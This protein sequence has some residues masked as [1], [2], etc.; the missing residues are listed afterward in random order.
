MKGEILLR[1]G[2]LGLGN[3]GKL[4]LMNAMRIKGISVVAAADKSERSRKFAEKYHVK[5]Y[6]DYRTLIDKED[7]DAVIISLPNFLKKESVVYA[8]EHDLDVF[9]DK[10]LAR[11]SNEAKEIVHEVEN[12]KV[13]LM[14]GVNYRYF[15][16]VQKLKKRL[17]DG[18]IGD[19][20]IATSEL[21]LNGP[22][23]HHL[24]PTPVPDWWLNKKMAGGGALLDLGYHLIDIFTWMFGD[25]HLEYSG[26]GY[27]LNLPVEDAATVVL[28]SERTSTKCIV[29]VGWFSKSVFPGFNFRVNIHGTV[30]Y[31][32][33]DRYA[34][35]N[36]HIYA[37]KEGVL[38]FL[39]KISLRKINY[40]SYT[41][42]YSSFYKILE[43]FFDAIKYGAEF[44]VSL[45][46]QLEV[47]R[48][49][50]EAYRRHDV[51]INE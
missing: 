14:V 44:P 26:L 50:D 22:F 21:I 12:K 18:E 24:V 35:K 7:L 11:S 38:N 29:N 43:V 20:I 3:M 49:I 32:S 2:V 31:D 40:L 41:Y 6:D 46:G 39:R 16:S 19:V 1:V 47:T 15:D 34:P 17:D 42:Y 51:V 4:H 5:T 30:G 23:S 9:L 10:P 27:R 36:P 8:A 33:T 25:F 48:I 13:R 45:E 28:G 37:V